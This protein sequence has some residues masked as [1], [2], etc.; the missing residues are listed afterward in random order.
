MAKSKELILGLYTVKQ[1]KRVNGVFKQ[2][3]SD[4]VIFKDRK[5]TH[6]DAIR[7]NIGFYQNGRYCVE[8]K[9]KKEEK[10]K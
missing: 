7:Q 8:S 1:A 6:T 5:I 9:S 3:K 4:E 10:E 2:F